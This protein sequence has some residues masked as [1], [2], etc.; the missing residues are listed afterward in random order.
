MTKT[1]AAILAAGLVLAPLNLAGAAETKSSMKIPAGAKVEVRGTTAIINN[2][3]G[4]GNGVG[5][6]FACNCTSPDQGSCKLDTGPG[7]LICHRGD[8]AAACK[9]AC[10]LFTSTG[11]KRMQQQ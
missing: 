2:G 10:T 6:T 8:G 9:G 7:M 11:V 4:G 3:G 5:G 1:L